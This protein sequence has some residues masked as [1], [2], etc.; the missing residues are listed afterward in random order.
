MI[1]QDFSPYHPNTSKKPNRIAININ[2]PVQ[3]KRAIEF[4]KYYFNASFPNGMTAPDYITAKSYYHGNSKI[5]LSVCWNTITGKYESQITS[6]KII[7]ADS[8]FYKYDL[9]G[10]LTDIAKSL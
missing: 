3:Y 2:T 5:Y 8:N 9:I 7:K 4:S 6:R 1:I 10:N